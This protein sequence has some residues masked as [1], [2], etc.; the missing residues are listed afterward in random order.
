MIVSFRD[1]EE[2]IGRKCVQGVGDACGR[3]EAEAWEWNPGD[4][5]A[6]AL[7]PCGHRGKRTRLTDSP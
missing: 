6:S 7:S 4:D 3:N 1:T 5:E 2:E